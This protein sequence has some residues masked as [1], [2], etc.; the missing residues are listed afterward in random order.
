MLFKKER[1]TRT[2]PLYADEFRSMVVDAR[3]TRTVTTTGDLRSRLSAGYARHAHRRTAAVCQ[4]S[5]RCNVAVGR[6][7]RDRKRCIL[8]R[9]DA[10][11][12]YRKGE[13]GLSVTYTDIREITTPILKTC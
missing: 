2:I 6:V 1:Y 8:L 11:F 12:R 3:R 9:A 10:V 7:R 4:Y 13:G 5:A